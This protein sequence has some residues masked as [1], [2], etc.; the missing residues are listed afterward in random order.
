MKREEVFHLRFQLCGAEPFV[1]AGHLDGKPAGP[2]D[3]LGV[4]EADE[5]TSSAVVSRPRFVLLTMPV[6]GRRQAA[7][8]SAAPPACRPASA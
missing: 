3:R 8:I 4:A 1:A 5:S 6:K 7:S 2:G